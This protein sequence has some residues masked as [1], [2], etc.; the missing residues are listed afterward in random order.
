LSTNNNL[1]VSYIVPAVLTI[2]I[3]LV[4]SSLVYLIIVKSESLPEEYTC[5]TTILT[6]T[7]VSKIASPLGSNMEIK[8]PSRELELNG[9]DDEMKKQ[10][11]NEMSFCWKAFGRGKYELFQ[12]SKTYCHV[13]SYI[14]ADQTVKL[15]EFEKFLL[16]TRMKRSK[17]TYADYL[18][19]YDKPTTRTASGRNQ[20]METSRVDF[21]TGE[22]EL[23]FI[24]IKEQ[25][26][27]EDMNS[28]FGT[29]ENSI[30]FGIAGGTGMMLLGASLWPVTV[31]AG[32]IA[33]GTG[34]YSIF[35]EKEVDWMASVLLVES[36]PSALEDLGCNYLPVNMRG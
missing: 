12:E 13:C 30:G 29:L 6:N 17:L 34:I 19:G 35:K 20:I 10:L 3:L 14:T 7:F 9:N 15:E 16:E 28:K 27:F 33:A 25:G 26:L 31:T 21:I 4:L 24:Y 18:S 1:G 2:V 32:A 36:N 22:K 8:C 5:I 23:V 11:A